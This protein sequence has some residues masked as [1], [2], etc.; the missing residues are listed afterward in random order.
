MFVVECVGSGCLW[1][2]LGVLEHY[3]WNLLGDVE[4][5]WCAMEQLKWVLLGCS[6]AGSL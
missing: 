3:W 6:S 4:C 1:M 5:F 2:V